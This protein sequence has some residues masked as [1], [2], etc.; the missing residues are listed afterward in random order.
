ME[1]KHRHFVKVQTHFIVL[2]VPYGI[3]TQQQITIELQ[4]KVLIVPYG[5]ETNFKILAVTYT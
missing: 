1:L 3:E 2:I 4:E 5:I